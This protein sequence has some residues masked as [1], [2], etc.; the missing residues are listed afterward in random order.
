MQQQQ[1]QQKKIS[2]FIAN[3]FYTFFL[4]LLLFFFIT[5]AA[6][7]N[8]WKNS[9][10]AAYL[11]NLKYNNNQRRNEKLRVWLGCDLNE[12]SFF[13]VNVSKRFKFQRHT[14]TSTYTLTYDFCLFVWCFFVVVLFCLQQDYNA[15]NSRHP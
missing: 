4:L 10:F 12:Q 14:Q 9:N 7:V 8:P 6:K 11:F 3:N 1:H 2:F 13:I 5:T 15:F